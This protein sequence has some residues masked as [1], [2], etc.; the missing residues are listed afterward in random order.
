LARESAAAG[1]S[2][3]VHRHHYS[4]TAERAR[5]ASDVTGF[6]MLGAVLLNDSVGGVDPFV[7]DHALRMGAVVIGLP[8]LSARAFRAGMGVLQPSPLADAM[9]F[10]SGDITVTDDDGKL[11]PAVEAVIKLVSEANVA[12]DLGYVSAEEQLAVARAAAEM[13]H[14]RLVI[15]NARLSDDEIDQAMAIPGL[16]LEITSYAVHPSGRGSE[17]SAAGVVLNVELMRKVGVERIVLCS[18]GGMLNAPP[19]AEILAWAL[20]EYAAAGFTL[21]ELRAITHENPRKL[22]PDA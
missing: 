22:V 1:L 14:E 16:F 18:A 6:R 21:D 20:E 2:A 11:R 4:S 5:I 17:A 7:V 19:P 10:G 9:R 15:T 8:T 3:V 12:L 13:G